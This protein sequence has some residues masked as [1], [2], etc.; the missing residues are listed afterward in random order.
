[1]ARIDKQEIRRQMQRVEAIIHETEAMADPHH[2]ARVIEL[3]QLLMS[4][5][6]AGLDRL[7]E[8]VDEAGEPGWLLMERFADDELVSGMLLLYGLHPEDVE[9][10][11]RSALDKVRP[12]L[13]S[14]GGNVELLG[15]DDGTVSLRLV[16]SC[17]SCPSSTETLRQLI[18]EAVYEAAPDVTTIIAE[19]AQQTAANGLVQ[20]Q[21]RPDKTEPERSCYGS[22]ANIQTAAHD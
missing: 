17:R 11:V 1:M 9:T 2:K 15:I 3:V 13:N 19:S 18:E 8:L 16:G 5:H 10:R 4:L 21:A 12:Y 14:H 20:L 6:G 22:T 7:M